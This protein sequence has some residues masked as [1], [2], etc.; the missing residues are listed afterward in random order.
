MAVALKNPT[1]ST[2]KDL[3]DGDLAIIVG[4]SWDNWV[5]QRY[6]TDLVAIGRRTGHA[7]FGMFGDH[8][9]HTHLECRRL[10]A[11]EELVIN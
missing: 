11:G 8:N 6:K 9:P 5:V 10:Q 1:K 4:G 7:W 3:A 2:T